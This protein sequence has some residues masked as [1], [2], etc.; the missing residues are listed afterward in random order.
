MNKLENSNTIL[1]MPL[2]IKALSL[3]TTK[4]NKYMKFWYKI[5]FKDAMNPSTRLLKF[6]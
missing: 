3:V 6:S 1:G 4:M 5:H 2:E